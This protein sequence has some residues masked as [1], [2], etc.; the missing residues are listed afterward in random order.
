MAAYVIFM[1]ERTQNPSE[2]TIYSAKA[3]AAM[4]GYTVIPLAV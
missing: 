1:R 2:L 3:P 4:E